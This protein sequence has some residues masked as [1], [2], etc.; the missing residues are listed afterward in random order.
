MEYQ[1]IINL[2]DNK[3]SQ[4]SKFRTKNG[5]K[6]MVNQEK[7]IIPIVTLD[8]RLQ[9]LNLVYVIIVILTYLLKEE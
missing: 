1:K 6:Q 9:Y 4:L 3:S 8:S 2:L 5:L 7:Y